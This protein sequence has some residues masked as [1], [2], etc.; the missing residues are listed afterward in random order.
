[1]SLWTEEEIVKLRQALAEGK[2][3]SEVQLEG[4]SAAS[5]AAKMSRLRKNK[6]KPWTT[7]ERQILVD[8]YKIIPMEQLL[9]MLPERTAGSVRGQA[10]WLKAR[11]WNIL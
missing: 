10:S 11:G 9:E 2:K 3:A 5:I 8:Y 6:T 1:M 7:A 4:R